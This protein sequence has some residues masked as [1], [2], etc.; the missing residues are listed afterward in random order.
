MKNEMTAKLLNE[1]QAPVVVAEIL[2]G[3]VSYESSDY[4]L[5]S[6]I[7]DQKPDAALLSIALSFRMIIRPY[8]KASPIL[9][10]SVLECMRIVEARASGFLTSPLSADTSCPA[11]LDS[12]SSIAEDLSY[13][14]ELLDLAVNF[15]AAKDPLAM[16]LCALLKSQ[17]HTHHM[18]AEVFCNQ[19][20]SA[21][22]AEPSRMQRM[23]GCLVSA[24]NRNEPLSMQAV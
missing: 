5:S 1:L 24:A 7:S 16:R 20:A 15:F 18:I 2:N 14:E 10:A 12:M 4:A 19:F 11:T 13:V 9:K 23:L 17:A 6:L 22:I 8:I 21:P 3:H